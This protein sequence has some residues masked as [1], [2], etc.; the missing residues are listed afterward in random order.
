MKKINFFIPYFVITLS[1]ISQILLRE[2]N[3]ALRYP[4]NLIFI[5]ILVFAILSAKLFLKDTKLI[6]YFSSIPAAIGS[7]VPFTILVLFMGFIPQNNE[8]Q[9]IIINYLSLDNIINSQ[10]Y[11]VLSLYLVLVLSFTIV[12][13]IKPLT[14][15][16]VS[17][18]LNHFGL[19]LVIVSASMG[20]A[21]IIRLKMFCKYDTPC[22]Q[23]VDDKGNYYEMPFAL[24]LKK[25][26]IDEWNPQIVI[27]NSKKDETILS[28]KNDDL[29][30]GKIISI[31]NYKIKIDTFYTKS[32]YSNGKFHPIY[33]EGAVFSAHITL[34]NNPKINGWISS[35]SH[36]Y[37]PILLSIDSTYY[38]AMTNPAPKKY[39]SE[40]KLYTPDQ[41][42]KKIQIEVNK[43]YKHNEWE[44]YQISYDSSKG[45]WS[46]YSVIEVIKD[47]WLPV[48]FT[49][50]FML[51]A[52]SV[53][54]F[55]LGKKQKI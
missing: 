15:K 2:N 49:G 41:K 11:F 26:I 42:N 29:S 22:W 38:V 5:L 28:K 55:I 16:N 47:P 35:P 32:I 39:H 34:L 7:I 44:M 50:I 36:I 31:K 40:L 8:S 19:W 48:V 43:P 23:G 10:L 18:L 51:I 20:S 9:N 3:L 12:K 13:R 25:F 4:N 14:I 21:D 30:S 1:L 17:F 46:E 52:G 24:E 27:Y 53:L 33:S 45:Q 54:L 37:S 6:N